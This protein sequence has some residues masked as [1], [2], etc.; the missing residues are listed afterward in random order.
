MRRRFAHSPAIVTKRGSPISR[1]LELQPKNT[2]ALA[3][4]AS[5]GFGP[6][7]SKFITRSIAE[8]DGWTGIV[9][10]SPDGRWLAAG[11]RDGTARVIEAASGKGVSK[12]EF[13]SYVTSIA[14]SPD[15]RW[16]AVGGYDGTARVIEAASGKEVTSV[17][18]GDVVTSVAFSPDGRW[19][20]AAALGVLA[21][22][23]LA[24]TMQHGSEVKSAQFSPDG[25][26]IVTASKDD[27]AQLWDAKTGEP[28]G[29]PMKHEGVVKSAQFRVRTRRWIVTASEDNTARLWDATTGRPVGDPMKHGKTVASAQFSPDGG[30]VITASF[31]GTAR[32]WEQQAQQ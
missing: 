13:G 23:L 7:S 19:L 15:G 9:A 16:L 32:L 22:Q 3:A 21:E 10:F 28:V 8:T 2:A 6:S 5:Y 30:Y 1:A 11:S 18:F 26:W 20:A 14:F 12:V 4:S 31:D 29:E 27:T 24:Q 17:K 25:R